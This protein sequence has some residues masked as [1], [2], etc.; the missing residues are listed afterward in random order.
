MCIIKTGKHVQT[1]VDLQNLVTSIFLR[2]THSFTLDDI[3]RLLKEYL[4]GSDKYYSHESLSVNAK[5]VCEDTL[6]TLR[7][8]NCLRYEKE[9]YFLTLSF[10]S[11]Y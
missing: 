4:Q 8:S 9:K 1:H 6:K 5:K 3:E 10:P 2:Q 11:F 7:L